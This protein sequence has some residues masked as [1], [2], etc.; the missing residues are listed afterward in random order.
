MQSV[1]VRFFS[2]SFLALA[3]ALVA[4]GLFGLSHFEWYTGAYYDERLVLFDNGVIAFLWGVSLLLIG[5]L[6]RL[7]HRRVAM[8]LASGSALGVLVWMRATVPTAQAGHALFPDPE[9]LNDLIVIAAVVM[10]L[11]LA[12]RLIERA[13]RN[14][15]R[16]LRPPRMPENP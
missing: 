1:L 15:A 10:A 6:G 12:D 4:Y 9:L 3:C 14:V 11:A 2:S 8:L 5:Q 13:I 7:H 16:R